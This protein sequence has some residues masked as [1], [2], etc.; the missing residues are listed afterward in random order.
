MTP[1]PIVYVEIPAPDLDAASAFYASVF[2]WTV[3]ESDLSDQPYAMF[4]AGGDALSGGLDPSR[5]VQREGGVIL[6]LKVDDIAATLTAIEAAGGET[7]RAKQPI[8]GDYGFSAEFRDPN[9]NPVGLWAK[10]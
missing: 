3:R 9:G 10:D 2:G 7:V 5:A 4:S 8:G 1:S 6:Y